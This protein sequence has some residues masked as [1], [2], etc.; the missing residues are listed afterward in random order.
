M[1]LFQ[2]PPQ[3]ELSLC[4][5]AAHSRLCWYSV[6]IQYMII[7]TFWTTDSH[8]APERCPKAPTSRL[9]GFFVSDLLFRARRPCQ[10]A[11]HWLRDAEGDVDAVHGMGGVLRLRSP[12]H[13]GKG[14]WWYSPWLFT[15]TVSRT[16]FSFSLSPR[17]EQWNSLLLSFV[18]LLLQI[19]VVFAAFEQQIQEEALSAE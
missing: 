15:A 9:P 19:Y 4:W 18:V 2:V 6:Y 5:N 3:D 11:R 7:P 14:K 1:R 13:G 17:F 16:C 8:F 10:P 12:G